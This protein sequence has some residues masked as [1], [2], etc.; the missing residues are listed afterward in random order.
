MTGHPLSTPLDRPYDEAVG[1]VRAAL[2]ALAALGG[3][4]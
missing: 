1:D 2:A 3:V 4:R